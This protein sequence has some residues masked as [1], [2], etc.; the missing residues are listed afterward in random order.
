MVFLSYLLFKL[1]QNV[2][3]HSSVFDVLLYR[4]ALLKQAENVVLLWNV[5]AFAQLLNNLWEQDK[6]TQQNGAKCC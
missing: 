4:T 3:N 2:C 1:G 6:F 5:Q